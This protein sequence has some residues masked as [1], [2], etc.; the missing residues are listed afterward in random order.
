MQCTIQHNKNRCVV[1]FRGVKPIPVCLYIQF[2]TKL[3]IA[4]A[5][6]ERRATRTERSPLLDCCQLSASHV[7]AM[8]YPHPRHVT[9]CL[10]VII[11]FVLLSPHDDAAI[12]SANHGALVSE[13]GPDVSRTST[14]A[15]GCSLQSLAFGISAISGAYK[16]ATV[17]M[18]GTAG[19]VLKE[20]WILT[21]LFEN[22][23]GKTLLPLSAGASLAE[24]DVILLGPFG[25]LVETRAVAMAYAQR[26]LVIFVLGENADANNGA[27]YDGMTDVVHLSLGPRLNVSTPQYVRFP[28]WIPYALKPECGCSFPAEFHALETPESWHERTG[29]AAILAHHCPYPRTVLF[30]LLHSL[31]FGRVDAPSTAFHNTPW[32]PELSSTHVGTGKV[33]FLRKYRYNICPENSKSKDGG[34]ST[35]KLPQA[36]MA[37]SVPIFW[38]DPPDASMF[39]YGRIIIFDGNNASVVQPV[40]RLETDIAFRKDWFSRPILQKSADASLQLWCSNVIESIRRADQLIHPSIHD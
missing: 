22:A 25:S 26:A 11:G 8:M 40:Q 20:L 34:Y 36:L 28:W 21:W 35:E 3:Y 17:S 13:V 31:D 4:W 10:L 2:C 39:N 12:R 7:V 1:E 32:P 38:G 19:D 9:F 14:V 5:N 30:E 23:V 37:G 15:D 16:V 29:F 18:W 33:E 6:L 24:A 27:F